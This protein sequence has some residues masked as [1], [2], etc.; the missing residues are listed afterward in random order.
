MKWNCKFIIRWKPIIFNW[1]FWIILKFLF[2]I[3]EQINERTI[4]FKSPK[5]G[6]SANW[7]KV[8][9][10]HNKQSNSTMP[11][12]WKEILNY[13]KKTTLLAVLHLRP[14]FGHYL[15]MHRYIMFWCTKTYLVNLNLNRI[16]LAHNF[17]WF[18]I[19]VFGILG[20]NWKQ[21]KRN[22]YTREQAVKIKSNSLL[23][24]IT[25]ILS[26]DLKRQQQ[27]HSINKNE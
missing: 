2:C 9:I 1:N 14:A 20:V 26:F 21:T 3:F 12:K 15:A 10:L 24:S 18:N 23:R 6:D 7:L 5:V 16:W 4:K 25:G 11:T 22:R 17:V 19:F 27:Q 8:I 13:E